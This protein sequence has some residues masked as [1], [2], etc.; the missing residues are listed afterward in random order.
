[1]YYV[2]ICILYGLLLS[3]YMFYASTLCM[4]A[5]CLTSL[6]DSFDDRTVSVYLFLALE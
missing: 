2:M 1:M 3:V 4:Y 6:T 5:M